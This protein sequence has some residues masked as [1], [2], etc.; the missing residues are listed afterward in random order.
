[1][2]PVDEITE[3]LSGTFIN[4]FHCLRIVEL[5]KVSE[6]STKNI[7]GGYSSQ[8]M[9]VRTFWD[10]QRS[11]GLYT[12]WQEVVKLY[13]NNNLCLA[14]AA[15]LLM[16]N[17]NYEVPSLKRQIAK[18]QQTQRDCSR[19]EAEYTSNASVFKEQYKTVCDKM[20]IKGD[21]IK[22]EL[23]DLLSELPK[24]YSDVA[25]A[26]QKCTDI[27]DYYTAFVEFVS[28]SY[29]VSETDQ[30]TQVLPLLSYL[31]KNGNTTVYQWRTGQVPSVR[32]HAVLP[33]VI[34]SNETS[35]EQ[36]K[37]ELSSYGGIDWGDQVVP[38]DTDPSS[39]EID[40][41]GNGIELGESG[42]DTGDGIEWG[43]STNSN[44]AGGIDLGDGGGDGGIDW[45]DTGISIE[46][47]PT[48][49]ITLEDSSEAVGA[50]AKG[51]DALTILDNTET[52]NMFLD[53]MMEVQA[54]LTQRLAELK[55]DS[56]VV[57]VNQFQSAPRI[58]QIQSRET[59]ETMTAT[60]DDVLSRLTSM[61]VQNLCLLKS[62]PRYVD[63]LAE[64][65]QQKLRISEK[66]KT[67]CT[68][69]VEKRKAAAEQQR[70]LEPKLDV[71]RC[72]TKELQ[73]QIVQE[74]SK[75]YK[76]RPVNIMGEINSI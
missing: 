50:V 17:V 30:S 32:L 19:K 42:N 8:R 65:L 72:K 27:V 23:M 36:N 2:P 26:T 66:L 49:E 63:R 16:R 5:L 47:S 56:D 28:P 40:W 67:S 4:Y 60:I 6:S 7:F 52:R 76:N 68:N 34:E 57:A 62:S 22:S 31:L 70:D 48:P 10:S 18:C 3:L 74:I 51:N 58:I 71:I 45:G 55:K 24:I 14:E 44:D 39:N 33:S 29:Q 1:M 54:F 9:K 15:H 69:M 12:D 25:Q 35:T 41:G 21:K 38:D 11:K 37:T 64:S 61:R 20:G 73:A 53:E 13:E 59:V 75:K 43:D 46:G